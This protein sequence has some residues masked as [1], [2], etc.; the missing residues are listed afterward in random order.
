[1]AKYF[2][3]FP[4][5]QYSNTIIRDISKRMILNPEFKSNMDSYYPYELNP[6]IRADEVSYAYYENPYYDWL[7]YL[8]N[9]IIDPY[10]GW[11]ITDELLQKLIESKYGSYENS[12]SRIKYWRTKTIEDTENLDKISI[13]YYEKSPETIK[14]YYSPRYDKFKKLRGYKLR[15]EE[16]TVNTNKLVSYNSS[17]KIPSFSNNELIQIQYSGENIANGELVYTNSTSIVIKNVF[18]NTTANSTY[19]VNVIGKTSNSNFSS[20]N[21]I[22]LVENITNEEFIFWEPVYDFD[23]E[24]EK[25][26]S[27]K[28]IGLINDSMVLDVEEDLRVKMQKIIEENQIEEILNA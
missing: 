22:T 11:P 19:I 16:W 24:E 21:S 2:D 7:I 27:R 1:M 6:I 15:N 25:N 17:T 9:D 5:I 14:K 13:T 23:Y 4:T 8:A 3:R 26:A 10:Y 20:S 28:L 18:G 12:V